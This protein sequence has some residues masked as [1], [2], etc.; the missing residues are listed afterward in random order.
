MTTPERITDGLEVIR[1]IDGKFQSVSL[2]PERAALMGSRSH[3]ASRQVAVDELLSD[4]GLD[5]GAAD[6]GLRALA[7]IVVSGRSGSVAA[8]RY[9][10]VLCGYGRPDAE[11]PAP[12]H[13]LEMFGDPPKIA[14]IDGQIWLRPSPEQEDMIY[15]TVADAHYQRDNN[16]ISQANATRENHDNMEVV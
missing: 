11:A 16:A 1:D 15:K 12:E 2:S 10:D 6:S 8:L 7:A 3:G 14:M 4:R 13:K 5:P 9:L